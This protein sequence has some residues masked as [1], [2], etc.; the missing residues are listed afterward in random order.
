[1]VE[2]D[3]TLLR[4]F[5]HVERMPGDRIT[6]QIYRGESGGTRERGRPRKTWEDSVGEALAR[7]NIQ[8]TTNRRAV[9]RHTM[10]VRE[11]RLECTDRKVW[12]KVCDISDGD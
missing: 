5:G 10:S 6:K 1:M 12:R 7:H 8:T 11:A 4:W 3:R 9:M 2:C